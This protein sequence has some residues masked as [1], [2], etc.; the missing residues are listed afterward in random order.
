[1]QHGKWVTRMQLNDGKECTMKVQ[2]QLLVSYPLITLKAIKLAIAI[3]FGQTA[4]VHLALKEGSDMILNKRD[5]AT[6]LHGLRMIQC[7]GRLEGCAAGDC[8]HF[9]EDEPLSNEEIDA[10]IDVLCEGEVEL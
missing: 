1:M 4:I 10:L 8:T 6:I 2:Y 9:D 7:E 3:E 5:I